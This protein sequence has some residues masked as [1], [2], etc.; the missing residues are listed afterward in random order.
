MNNEPAW[1]VKGLKT[2]D[3]TSDDIY[4]IDIINQD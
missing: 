3:S 4:G 2:P 1:K